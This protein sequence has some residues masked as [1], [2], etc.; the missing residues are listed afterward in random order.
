MVCTSVKAALASGQGA[1]S[2]TASAVS[3]SSRAAF[4]MA[5]SAAAA[6]PLDQQLAARPRDRVGFQCAAASSAAIAVGREVDRHVPL[7]AVG[8]RMQQARPAAGAHLAHQPCG[9]FMHR[10]HVVAVDLRGRD[11]H[12]LGARR[13]TV[14]GRHRPA[15]GGRAPAVVFADEEH[16]QRRTPAPSSALREKARG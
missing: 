12:R 3:T 1:A 11:V 15:R 4:S 10:E 6:M 8:Q 9:G 5:S 14:A 2:A 7:H 13:G 16:G